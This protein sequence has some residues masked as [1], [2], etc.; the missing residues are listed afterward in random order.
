MPTHTCGSCLKV[1]ER[2]VTRGQVPKWCDHC[3]GRVSMRQCECCELVKPL[4]IKAKRCRGCWA[5][6]VKARRDR[7][8]PV[9]Y[10]NPKR[11]A[12]EPV[13]FRAKRTLT[14]GRCRVCEAWFVSTS[15]DVTC[16]AEC[17]SVRHR[18]QRNEHK[19][20]RRARQ[21]DAFVAPVFRRKIFAADGYR[22]HLCRSL[23][24]RDQV[25]P[26]PKA[27]T[28]DHVIPLA[29]GGTHEPSNCRTAC[30]ACNSTKGDRGSGDQMLLLQ[31]A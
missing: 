31:I 1:W 19:L 23:T 6:D 24:D 13:H 18:D 11:V 9:L 21:K 14:S 25:V 27:P 3:R 5:A 29:A 28:I 8:L 17:Q 22:C 10:V 15:R 26:H 12:P 16:S 7:K 2:P 30:F 20:R 4:T